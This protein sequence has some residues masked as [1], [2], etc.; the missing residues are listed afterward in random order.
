MKYIITESKLR[1]PQFKY[2]DYLFEDMY[3]SKEYTNSEVWAKDG[4]I[5]LQLE[6]SGWLWVERQ[7]WNHIRDMFSIEYPEIKELM[8]EWGDEN[9][10]LDG[11]TLHPNK[12][13]PFKFNPD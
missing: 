10:V 2:L 11:I 1:R 12:I 4:E 9:L 3:K 7:I 5:I 13:N 6:K 8:K